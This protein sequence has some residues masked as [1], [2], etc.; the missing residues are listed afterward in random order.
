MAPTP[1]AIDTTPLP[2]VQHNGIPFGFYHLPSDLYGPAFS[3]ALRAATPA[4]VLADLQA[5]RRA[6]TRVLLGMVGWNRALQG[7]NGHFSIEKW[8]QRLDRYRSIDLSPYIADGTIVGHYMMD[9]PHDPS[10]W[11]GTPVTPAEIEEMARY[12]K[13]IWPD[14]A[15]V[16]RAWPDYLRGFS[17]KYL[18]AAWAQFSPG[19]GARR[20]RVPIDVFIR[21]NVRGAVSS[22]LRLVVGLNAL[23]GSDDN[24]LTGY[25]HS[26]RA[27]TASQVRSW[28]SALLDEPNVCA[29][30]SW[31]YGKAYF[32]RD[33]VSQ[34]LAEL[35]RKASD[36]P[37]R[38]CHR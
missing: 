2:P 29:F 3:G 20:Y 21:E 35:G 25:Y 15:T 27:M 36:L 10:N 8:K 19:V 9:E 33:D 31:K 32:E 38:P 23:A 4:S 17:F 6:G 13:Q 16:I 28:G 11:G 26:G 37:K 12:S 34:A 5:A 24:G 1:P 7:A 30:M 18:D 14:M 22:G